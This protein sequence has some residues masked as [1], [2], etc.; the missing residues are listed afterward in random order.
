MSPPSPLPPALTPFSHDAPTKGKW[1]TLQVF[2]LTQD[3]E[4]AVLITSLLGH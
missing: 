1:A 2:T 4:D 3:E